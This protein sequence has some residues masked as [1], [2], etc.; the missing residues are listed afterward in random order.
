MGMEMFLQ[1]VTGFPVTLNAL[2]CMYLVV[3]RLGLKKP[4]SS[5]RSP[6]A[7]PTASDWETLRERVQSCPPVPSPAQ[8]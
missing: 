4:P 5:Q 3:Y 6:W 2:K 8:S 1:S 7:T